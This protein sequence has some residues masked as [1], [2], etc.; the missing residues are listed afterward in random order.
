VR[1]TVAIG[2]RAI[3]FTAS[4]S[5]SYQYLCP[6]PGHAAKGMLGAFEVTG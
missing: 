1:P 4:S 2:V 5:G 6:V 3:T